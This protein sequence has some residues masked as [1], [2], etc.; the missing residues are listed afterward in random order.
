ML[1]TTDL[2]VETLIKTELPPLPGTVIR[3][4]AMLQDYNVS[5]RAVANA[6]SQD[7]ALSLRILRLANSPIYA[8]QRTVSN[9]SD[10][11]AAVG[12]NSIAESLMITGIGDSFGSRVL[13]SEAGR[14]IWFHLLATAM[15]AGD[16]CR[17]AKLRGADEAFSGG[18]LHDIGKL[19]LLKADSALYT[20][21]LDLGKKEGDVR[22]IEREIFGFDHVEL[23]F[24]AAES[25]NLPPGVC[26]MIRCHH[27]PSLATEGIA[28][29][30]VVSLANSLANLKN[31]GLDI[32]D[33]LMSETVIGFGF[34]TEQ[35]EEIW[36]TTLVRIRE[37][38]RSL[39]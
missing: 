39:F 6:I 9:M 29:T 10:A 3:I 14:E 8:L 20:N 28:V 37:V 36:E 19:I 2:T 35:F 38:M 15:T 23:G 31:Q 33:L 25:W 24:R 17:A 12:N 27:D 32:D 4:S 1:T 30:R 11:V 22:D 16:M 26:D 13:N 34:T 18:L 21:V 5:Q 7:P